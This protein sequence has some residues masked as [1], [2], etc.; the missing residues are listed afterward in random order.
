M[1]IFWGP[2]AHDLARW[3][4]ARARRRSLAYDKAYGRE[5]RRQIGTGNSAADWAKA[6][7]RYDDEAAARITA[8]FYRAVHRAAAAGNSAAAA[9]DTGQRESLDADDR[10]AFACDRFS[11]KIGAS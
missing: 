3:E 7:C 9:A 1:R 2:G 8:R 10:D 11:R 5:Y 4:A 6:F